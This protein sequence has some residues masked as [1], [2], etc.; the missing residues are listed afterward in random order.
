[1]RRLY[2]VPAFG[3]S[4]SDVA[5]DDSWG[6]AGPKWGMV[7]LPPTPATPR[8]V[9]EP[10]TATVRGTASLVNLVGRWARAASGRLHSLWWQILQAGLAA[11]VAWQISTSLLDLPQTIFAPFAAIVA[12]L[13]GEGG[14]GRRALMIALGVTVGVV[15]G[16]LLLLVVSANLLTVVLAALVSL[17]IVA[18]FAHQ[19]LPLNHGAIASIIVLGMG[20][21]S[22]GLGRL[23]SAVI[24]GL[25]ALLFTQVLFTPSPVR[26]LTRAATSA[27]GPIADA[28]S[29]CARSVERGDPGPAVDALG[30]VRECAGAVG[31]LDALRG[32]ARSTVRHTL[33]G[34][35]ER[36]RFAAL[37]DRLQHVPVLWAE[38]VALCGAVARVPRH[39]RYTAELLAELT[40]LVRGLA[41]APDLEQIT[42]HARI[43]AHSGA[44]DHMSISGVVAA[45]RAIGGNTTLVRPKSSSQQS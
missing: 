36:E 20:D 28:L 14:R 22:S 16:E 41:A 39:H 13:G 31:G 35:R 42:A 34:R 3:S 18:L 23:G 10:M 38:T 25:V 43:A 30:P 5:V 37:D 32:S 1:M 11:G 17:T 27:L 45:V 44:S 2:P 15:V 9:T 26:L 19:N 29:A 4:R 12:L 7:R 8:G 40:D 33:R 6:A 24:G 21:S